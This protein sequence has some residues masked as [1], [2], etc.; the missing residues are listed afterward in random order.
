[1]QWTPAG[2]FSTAPPDQQIRPTTLAGRYGAKQINVESQQRDKDSLLRWF[3]QLIRV[4]RECPEIGVGECFVV[5]VELPRSV[6][7]HRFAAPE[8][9]IVL[10]HNLA[11]RAVTV[12][13]GRLGDGDGGDGDD[14]DGPREVFSD[15]PYDEP[16]PDLT[17]LKLR[18]HGYRWIRLRRSLAG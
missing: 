11:D 2:G 18:G 6:L 16:P 7:A 17:G 1:M 4:L 13:L 12:D 14:D 15:G 8:G 9:E 5:D 3:E 10:L